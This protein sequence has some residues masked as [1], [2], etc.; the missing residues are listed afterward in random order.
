METST[1]D[2]TG[3]TPEKLAIMKLNINDAER[4]YF[5]E[6]GTPTGARKHLDFASVNGDASASRSL[7]RTSRQITRSSRRSSSF[8][9]SHRNKMSMELTAKAEGKFFALMDLMANASREA[10]SLKE[11]WAQILSERESFAKEREE[12]LEQVTEVTQ[13]LEL[14]ESER[15]RHV[16]E[17]SERKRQVEKLLLELSTAL[18]NVSIEKKKLAERDAELDRVRRELVEYRDT[19][20]RTRTDYEKLRSEFDVI[21]LALKT[22]EGDRD[23]ARDEAD[24]HYREL[25]RII[26]ERTEISGKLSD[27][28]N[29]HELARKELLS[30][31]DRIKMY[32]LERDEA[33]HE[34]DRLR[35]DARK[36]R[37]RADEAAKEVL[38]HTEKQERLTREVTKLKETIRAIDAE[39][40]DYSHTIEHLRRELKTI[41]TGRDEAEEKLSEISLKY[42]QIKREVLTLKEKLRDIELERSEA[43]ESVERSREQ[44]RLIVIERDELKDELSTAERKAEDARRQV[45]NLGETLRKAEQTVT[46]LRSEVFSLTE[47]I[48]HI[49]IERD[50]V[51][52]KNGHLLTEIT[53]LR[54]KIVVFQA[55]I[56]SIS[57]ARDRFRGELD[58]TR[59]EF[60]EITETITSYKDDSGELEFEIESLRTMLR[61][62]REQKERAIAA[63]NAADRERD[64]YIAKYEEKCREMERFEESASS[65]YRAQ[66]RSDGR[67]ISSS[68]IVSRSSTTVNNSG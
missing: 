64:E 5:S 41:T 50:E 20:T 62:A 7:A 1:L 44:H 67:T 48:K 66:S 19:S 16:H 49:D 43:Y 32:D 51:R 6:P 14:R 11:F 2:V 46:E 17:G 37:L 53:D 61:D 21:E 22:A 56:R 15:H 65:H 4:D 10:S 31:T 29:K 30:L 54:E 58:K 34:A 45:I 23:S 18:G 13:E 47:R 25:Q 27:M 36:A 57:E 8:M 33:M 35:E 24:R 68:R 3:I 40:D 26:R 52:T 12:L 55:E 42:E 28:T 39:R 38:E 60:E 9:A 63:R 59:R